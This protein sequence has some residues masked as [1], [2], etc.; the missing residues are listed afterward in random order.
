LEQGEGAGRRREVTSLEDAETERTPID[1]G[2]LAKEF[3]TRTVEDEG[4]S[5]GSEA[6]DGEGVAG[7]GGG[8]F[9]VGVAGGFGRGEESVHAGNAWRWGSGAEELLGAFEERA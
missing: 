2:N 3:V 1:I 6:Q 8:Q 9:D 5:S 7:F 4:L